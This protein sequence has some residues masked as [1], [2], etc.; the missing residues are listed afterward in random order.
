[1]G[2]ARF[3]SFSILIP[4]SPFFS[5]LNLTRSWFFQNPESAL[6]FWV[7]SLSYFKPNWE[8]S[9]F[10]GRVTLGPGLK[11]LPSGE[12]FI[13]KTGFGLLFKIRSKK[14]YAGGW[15]VNLNPFSR[16]ARET[17]YD[18]RGTAR[19]TVIRIPRATAIKNK[20]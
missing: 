18:I 17:K 8:R 9:L 4:F 1:M 16:G 5:L 2:S 12:F 6:G 10:K 7:L 20:K 13:Q 11:F 15:G 19:D 14:K 3:V